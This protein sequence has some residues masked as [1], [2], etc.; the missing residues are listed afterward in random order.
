MFTNH[1]KAL[2][3]NLL[4]KQLL[5]RRQ[6]PPLITESRDKLGQL[7]QQQNNDINNITNIDRLEHENYNSNGQEDGDSNDQKQQQQKQ[8]RKQEIL[9]RN[10]YL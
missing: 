9:E 3:K 2:K 1:L 7:L 10:R 5:Q 6:K 4:V 8:K